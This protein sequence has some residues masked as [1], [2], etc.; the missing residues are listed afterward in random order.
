MNLLLNIFQNIISKSNFDL[1]DPIKI[2][3]SI[4]FG[5]PELKKETIKGLIFLT[6]KNNTIKLDNN[7][8]II[9]IDYILSNNNDI[10]DLLDT[11]IAQLKMSE[12][13]EKNMFVL[14]FKLLLYYKEAEINLPKINQEKIIKFLKYINIQKEQLI[15]LQISKCINE[16]LKLGGYNDLIFE[17]IKKIPEENRSFEMN[18][19]IHEFTINKRV[20]EGKKTKDI[21]KQDK[22]QLAID[23]KMSNN[24]NLN[25]QAEIENNLEDPNILL[26]YLN[27][28]KSNKELFKTINLEKISI[29]INIKNLELFKLIC[30]EKRFWTNEALSNL[31]NGFY[32][33]DNEL[34]KETFAIFSSIEKYQK[35]PVNILTN[36]EIEKK[37]SQDSY[38]HLSKEDKG[39]YKQM[40]IDFNHLNGFSNRHKSFIKQ[41]DNFNYEDNNL[42]YNDLINLLINKNFD[43]GKTAFYKSIKNINL[44]HFI[45]IFAKLLSNSLINIDYKIITLKRLDNE[46][47]KETIQNNILVSMIIQIKFFIDW[48]ILPSKLINTFF[49]LLKKYFKEEKSIKKEIIFSIGNY[50]SIQKNNE[51]ELF[52]QFKNLIKDEELYKIIKSNNSLIEYKDED[53]FYIYSCAQYYNDINLS[54]FEK[55]PIKVI[56][57]YI[58]ESQKK[59][60]FEEIEAKINK[61]SLKFKSEDLCPKRDVILR[62]L[63][64]TPNPKSLDYLEILE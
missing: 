41:I 17:I 38:Y 34:I 52:I 18:E 56:M 13:L 26:I 35:I 30:E 11:I 50:F 59:Y 51:K 23:L 63:F 36:L 24:L 9:F 32:K 33:G 6:K 54:N 29:Y 4:L 15:E 2:Y 48:L 37:L 27:L 22:Y 10:I 40:I 7:F 3:K 31:L 1:K 21:I 39:I 8:I 64:I 14:L 42:I 16:Y 43:I 60:K 55:I 57:K 47:K 58:S 28:L 53:I 45:Q 61:F 19:A 20:K 62:Q 5:I 49:F 44:N 25:K 12:K 46:L